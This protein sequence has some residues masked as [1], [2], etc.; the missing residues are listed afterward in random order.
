MGYL[1]LN[2]LE[3]ILMITKPSYEELERRVCELEKETAR[4]NQVEKRLRE[5]VEKYRLLFN[6]CNDAMF[7][8]NPERDGMPGKFVEVNDITCQRYGYTREELLKMTPLSLSAPEMRHVVP[9]RVKKLLAERQVLFETEQVTKKGKRI[10]VEIHSRLFELKGQPTVIS[11]ARD[12]TERKRVEEQLKRHTHELGERVKELNCLF[13]ISKLVEKPSVSLEEILQGIVD[14]IPAAWRYPEVACARIVM[15]GQEFKTANFRETIWILSDGVSEHDRRIACLEVCYLEEK[16]PMDEGPFLKEERKLL[17]AICERL[18][19]IIESKRAAEALRES[20]ER[21]RLL[22]NS[23]NDAVFVHQPTPVGM[24]GRFIAVNEVGCQRYGYTREELLKMTPL[25]L[26]AREEAKSVRSRVK[27]LTFGGRIMFETAHLTKEG[28]RIPVEI[29]SQLF[30]LKGQPTVLSVV[31]DMSDRKRTEEHIHALTQE[32]MRAQESERQ[33]ISRELHDRVGQDLSTLKIGLDTL[34]E[35]DP[36]VQSELREKVLEYSGTLQ[37]TIRG[38]RDLA[39]DLRPPS[40]DQLSVVQA[41][42]QYCQDFSERTGLSLDFSSAGLDDLRLD[43]DTEINLSR[44]IQ[45]GLNNIRKH[46][47]A[48]NAKVRLISSFPNIILHIEDDGRGFDVEK[49]MATITH[50]KRMGLRSMEERVKL[51]GGEMMIRSR[52]GKGTRISIEVPYREKK[53]GTKEEN[54]DH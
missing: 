50:E 49:R 53:S 11:V 21:Y 10:P 35:N 36:E 14:L 16:P 9:T 34:F 52:P 23:G 19:K 39:Y 42:Y 33:M 18:G 27:K 47:D 2:A 13:G 5:N 37:E 30:D 31:R 29:S 54:T 26:S 1:F 24:P 43:F 6:S 7:V 20:E 28:K 46:A 8:W 3:D 48:R 12:S 15:Q 38:V 51:L 44:L 4:R 41:I 45:E 32:L 40:I 17:H 22:F 25:S